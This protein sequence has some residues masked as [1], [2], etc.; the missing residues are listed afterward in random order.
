MIFL[1]KDK[2]CPLLFIRDAVIFP[3]IMVE[4]YF[5]SQK[6]LNALK[7]LKIEDDV[8]VVTEKNFSVL[9]PKESDLYTVGVYGRIIEITKDDKK[10]KVLFEGLKR[11]RI[12]KYLSTDSYFRVEY[13]ELA[14]QKDLDI[15]GK[16]LFNNFLA[17]IRKIINSG[18]ILPLDVIMKIL[19]INEPNLLIN[20]VIPLLENDISAKQKILETLDINKRLELSNQSINKILQIVS[21]EEKVAKDTEAELSKS[22][23]EVFLREELKTIQKELGETE[24]NEYFEIERQIRKSNMPKE[25]EAVAIKELSH[26]RKT[27][28]FSPE[29]SYIRNYLDWLITMPWGRYS[30]EEINLVEAKEILDNDHYGLE[31]VKERILEYLAVSKA[32]GKIKGPIL[33]FTGA[34]GTGKTSIGR[35]IA[36]SLAREFT[37]ISLGGIRDEAEIR[38]HRRTYVGAM[39]GRII[40]GIRRT[41]VKNPVFM[42]DEVDKMGMDFRGDP[43]SALLEA[44]DPEQNVNFSDHYLEVFFDLSDVFFI[45]TANVV[46]NIPPAL[47]D[48]MEIIEFPGYTPEEKF[49]IAD[50]FIW[51][52]LSN[53]HG[54]DKNL[55]KK[56]SPNA[57]EKIISEYTREAGVR[58]IERQLAKVARKMVYLKLTNE[59]LPSKIDQ[60]NIE[61]FVGLPKGDNWAREGG[62]EVGLVTALA[63]TEAG[64]EVLSIEATSMRSGNHGKLTLT[65]HLGDIMK[66][67]A[68]AALTYARKISSKINIEKNFFSDSDIHVHVPMGAVSKDGPSAGVAIAIAIISAITNKP[69]NS[70]VGMT[71]EVTIRGRV[72]KIGGLREKILAAK[73]AN[74]KKV[75]IPAS[76]KPEFEE[77]KQDYRAGIEFYLV[78]TID[79]ILPIVF[80][81]I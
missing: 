14:D 79:E 7:E 27:P 56:L 30:S 19:S 26:L 33:C 28:S 51:P 17:N 34:P 31:K 23:K 25:V 76:N 35:S 21:L 29:I 68:E 12:K 47:R 75:I 2:N 69:I 3:D 1:N 49:E 43:S 64:G 38:G 63:V 62:N 54:L 61:K 8:C 41:E 20:N 18:K 66:E 78:N 59:I 46:E 48:R 73:R 40:Q 67:S 13:E 32:V 5:S 10:N 4:L 36:H 44:L 77:I 52:K 15:T 45:T 65:G 22:Q 70:D 80:N 53:S 6:S 74:L 60:I 42:L 81:S 55:S 24:G 16:T 50:K 58:E 72:L 71:G 39:P 37:R 11:I 57:I 9:D